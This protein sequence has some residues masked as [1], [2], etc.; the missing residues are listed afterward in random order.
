LKRYALSQEDY[1]EGNTLEDKINYFLSPTTPDKEG[2][3]K[4]P[5][6]TVKSTP[7]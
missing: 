1:E 3:N 5:L 6:P 4:F 7:E 2:N